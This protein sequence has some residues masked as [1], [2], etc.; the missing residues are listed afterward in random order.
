V[1]KASQTFSQFQLLDIYLIDIEI[2]FYV[3]EHKEKAS[4]LTTDYLH[5]CDN[6]NRFES[7]RIMCLM[8]G[9]LEEALQGDIV[10]LEK[11]WLWLR[12]CVTVKA[13]LC[14]LKCSSYTQCENKQT[15]N[16]QQQQQKQN[17]SP[18]GCA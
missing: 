14:G 13:R 11:V 15:K 9:P 18:L 10:L 5:V 16:K 6:L 1:S 4:S 3:Y 8:F 12:K 7:K 2:H 17:Q